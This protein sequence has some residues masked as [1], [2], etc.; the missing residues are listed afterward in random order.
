VN[1]ISKVVRGELSSDVNLFKG[2]VKRVYYG[3]L[4]CPIR[5]KTSGKM[6][7]VVRAQSKNGQDSSQITLSSNQKT[8]R[9]ARLSKPQPPPTKRSKAG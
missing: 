8:I 6:Q 2:A 7:K 5:R 4:N 3:A 1:A 9:T